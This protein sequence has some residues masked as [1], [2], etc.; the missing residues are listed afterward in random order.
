MKKELNNKG[1]S[2]VELIVVIA[3]MVV[4]VGVT[5]AVILNYM[6]RTK[7][8]KDMSALDSIHTAVKLYVGGPKS[9]LP[10]A[11]E[12]VTLKTLIT[13]SGTTVY[14]PEGII[15]SALRESFDIQQTGDTIS[16]CTFRGDSKVFKDINWEDIYVNID[17]GKVSIVVPVNDGYNEGYV[18]YTAGSYAWADERK[19]KE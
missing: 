8:G 5:S 1:F 13:G 4:L 9:E 7:Y 2:L 11:D 3:I 6:D 14:D 19:I 10:T 17:N 12:E 15:I 16:S 18:A